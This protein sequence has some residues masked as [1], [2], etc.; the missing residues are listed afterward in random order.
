MSAETILELKNVKV[1]QGDNLVLNNVNCTLNKGEFVYLIGKTGSGKSSLLKTLYGELPLTEGEGIVADIV[2]QKIK[3]SKIPFLR[4]RIG[5]VFQDFQLLADRS[6]E[7]NLE[8]V[9]RAT[10][11]K[12]KKEIKAKIEDVLEQVGL[13]TKGFKFPHQ[14]SGGEQ[15]RVAIARALLNDP[16]LILAD[17]P[18]GNLDPETSHRILNLL[19]DICKKGNTV[20]M[21]THDYSLMN[22]YHDRT[23]KCENGSLIESN[24]IESI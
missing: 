12:N 15:Q 11:W 8:F 17:E 4:R 5:I 18:T 24:A 1:Y 7:K 10:G 9:L 6:I 2:L 3:R 20:L 16:D 14:L 13:Q 21:A 19:I 22:L 23:L